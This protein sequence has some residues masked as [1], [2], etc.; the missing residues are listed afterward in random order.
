MLSST[1]NNR[2]KKIDFAKPVEIAEDIFWV[3]NYLEKDPFQCHPYLIKDHDESI[4]VDPG[5]MIQLDRFIEKIRSATD[6]SKIKYIILHHQDPDLCAA[7]PTLEKL[8]NN[9]ELLIVTHSR[10]SVLIKHYGINASYYNVDHNDFVLK[11]K[12]R[13]FQ[14]YTTPYC[15]SP[16]AFVTYD[17]KTKV[18][19]SS[20]IFGGL[21]DSWQFYA[22]ENYFMSIEGFHLAYMP[23]RD[24]LNYALNKIESLDI[25]LIAPQHGSLIRKHLIKPLIE[26]MKKMDCGLYI[27]KKYSHDLL[28]TIEK[29]NNLQTEFEVSLEEIKK[30][31]RQM[32]GDYFLTSLL[33]H[34]LL[35]DLNKS[36]KVRTNNVIIQH[37]SFMF[38][39]QHYQLGGDICISGNLNFRNQ[40]WTFFFNSDSMGKSI[41]GA[42]GS[43]V[44]GTVINSILTRSV[45][46]DKLLLTSPESWLHEVYEEIQTIFLS[47]DGAMMVSAVI[48]LIHD[49]TGKMLYINAEH[50][51]MILYRNG[52]ATYLEHELLQRKFGCPSEFEFLIQEYQLNPK[53]IVFLGSDGKDD[54]NLR[55]GSDPPEINQ[56]E[57]LFLRIIERNH[58]NLRKIVQDIFQIGEVMDD[59]S[60]I[61]V[62][63]EDEST[64]EQNLSNDLI[65][66]FRISNCIRNKNYKKALDL[67]EGPSEKQTPEILVSRG[68]CLLKEKRYLKSLKYLTLAIK[69]R[70]DY[71]QA[72]KYAGVAH[73]QMGNLKKCNYYWTRAIILD[74]NDKLLKRFFPILKNRLAKQKVL[75]G[76]KQQEETKE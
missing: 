55:P 30:L 23:N 61:R 10:M 58:G 36:K 71:F 74:E 15:H 52:K 24:I 37:K 7:V 11:T 27:D 40:N 48:A 63:F 3:G 60:I 5:S 53:D 4:L 25:E 9:P 18:L 28:R 56:D 43:L 12:Y 68:Y 35:L 64:E 39:N 51:F 41:Q 57:D 19:F 76:K 21:E 1:Q 26:K 20:D 34:P 50:P 47:F 38:K 45:G 31:K 22:D 67:M 17:P 2:E 6:L 49:E 69:Q 65:H 44:M 62:G 29:L 72:L 59:L 46:K 75:L 73:F 14:F 32:D 54:I 33:M 8:I 70:S 42:G 66:A 16:G 13:N